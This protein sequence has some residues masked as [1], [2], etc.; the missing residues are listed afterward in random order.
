MVQLAQKKEKINE[1]LE[2]RNQNFKDLIQKIAGEAAVIADEVEGYESEEKHLKHVELLNKEAKIFQKNIDAMTTEIEN[3]KKNKDE[4][5]TTH[6]MVKQKLENCKSD[7]VVEVP[8]V[9]HMLSL[10]AN[11][12]NIKW[13]YDS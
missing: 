11:L 5:E 8:R 12:T 13:N 1:L 9:N 10:Y 6:S 4:M 3:L 2:S 7:T